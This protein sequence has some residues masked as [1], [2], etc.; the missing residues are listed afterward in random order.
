MK[1][2][3]H[4]P[5]RRSAGLASAVLAGAALLLAA[6]RLFASQDDPEEGPLHVT[7]EGMRDALKGLATAI[8]DPATHEDALVHVADLQAHVLRAKMLEP[9]NLDEIP[10]DQRP[11]HQ[12]AFRRDMAS[13]L[14]LLAEAEIHLLDGDA[15]AVG[16]MI[17]GPLMELRDGSHEKYQKAE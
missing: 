16:A 2:V 11:A 17:R 8:K 5:L 13:L 10:A 4:A 3:K 6:P 14:G 12:T 15:E 1:H 7:M 9:S